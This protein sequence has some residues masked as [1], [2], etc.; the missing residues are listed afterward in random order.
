MKA[1]INWIVIIPVLVLAV[2]VEL[3]TA[4]SPEAAKSF[5]GTDP[6]GVSEIIIIS[7]VVLFAL[8]FL[9]SL[10]DRKTSPVHLL[11]KNYPAGVSAVIAAF[12]LAGDTAASVAEGLRGSGMGAMDVIVMVASALAA[13]ALLLAG[14]N[15]CSGVNTKNNSAFLYLSVPLW[16]GA[17]L[18]SR[19]MSHTATPVSMAE[20]LDLVMYVFMAIYFM[21][22]FMVVSL[23]NGKNPVKATIY[24][25]APAAVSALVYSASLIGANL[26]SESASVFGY[27]EAATTA[28]LGIYILS[29]VAELSFMSKTK[30]EQIIIT[31]EPQTEEAVVT[32]TDAVVETVVPVTLEETSETT[33]VFAQTDAVEEEIQS[34]MKKFFNDISDVELEIEPEEEEVSEDSEDVDV[35]PESKDY[36]SYF[37]SEEPDEMYIESENIAVDTTKKHFADDRKYPL[38]DNETVQQQAVRN[39][40]VVGLDEVGSVEASASKKADTQPTETDSDADDS[41]AARLD[42]IDRLII[43]IQG[44]EADE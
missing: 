2:G 29:F 12:A 5:F 8:L 17:H 41:Y 38:T 13:V 15:H 6:N 28:F 20:T 9:L 25:G 10:F 18:L 16:C 36:G 19:F 21:Y 14:I 24:W 37:D 40:Y 34:N 31:N 27:L 32:E 35:I 42:E 4:V 26:N 23:I 11:K 43:S 39:E 1:I 30:E 33:P 3:F 7:L 44:G 22:S